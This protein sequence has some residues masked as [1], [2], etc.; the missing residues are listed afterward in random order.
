MPDNN[1]SLDNAIQSTKTLLELLEKCKDDE[2]LKG[3][4]H[5]I[6]KYKINH[7]LSVDIYL[8]SSGYNEKKSIAYLSKTLGVELFEPRD[9]FGPVV[10]FDKL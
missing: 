10:D 7:S 1:T 4:L 8:S 5:V 2:K 6:S 9:V 3:I